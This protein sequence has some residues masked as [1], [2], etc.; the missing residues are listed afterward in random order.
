MD[1]LARAEHHVRTL[2]HMLYNVIQP[3]RV[4]ALSEMHQLAASANNDA[5][6]R[7]RINAYLSSGPL[8]GALTELA[9]AD[10]IEIGRVLGLLETVSRETPEQ[11]VGASAR[12]LEVY[13]DHP[14]LLVVRGAGESL[15][16]SP[17][18]EVITDSFSRAFAAFRAYRVSE[19]EGV[20]LLEWAI[21]QLRNYYRG[22]GWQFVG[23]IYRLWTEA[24]FATGQL[25]QIENEALD[26]ARQGRWDSGELSAVLGNRM[27][28]AATVF[29]QY[30][31]KRAGSTQ[32]HDETRST[33]IV[34]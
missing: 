2:V 4:R 12:Q 34:S 9:T 23:E 32:T 31:A 29:A 30:V 18:I 7:T 24:G 15:L 1:L 19:S 28:R 27:A 33:D 25:E 11:W 3:A 14:V 5:D 21:R 17:D 8:A 10:H 26:F 13:P 22:R 6:I 16:Q 20:I